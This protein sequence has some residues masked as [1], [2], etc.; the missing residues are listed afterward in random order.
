MENS[1]TALEKV[2]LKSKGVTDEMLVKFTELGITSKESFSVVGDA[3]T[4]SD[5]TGL[6][7]ENASAIMEWAGVQSAAPTAGA[8]VTTGPG[9]TVLSTDGQKIVVEDSSVIKC[10]HCDHKQPHDYTS[11]DLCPNCG[12]QAEPMT[13]CYWCYNVGSGKFCRSC[14]AEYVKNLDYEIAVLLKREGVSK[15][16]IARELA[17]MLDSEKETRLTQLRSGRY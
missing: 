15:R 9:G 16:E 4:L 14:G 11:G 17:A 12:K 10:T 2:I 13:N 1:L 5:I 6:S 3:K 8:N 7:P